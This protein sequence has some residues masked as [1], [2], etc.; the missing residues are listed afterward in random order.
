VGAAMTAVPYYTG[1]N[2]MWR[3][4]TQFF[5]PLPF[6]NPQ[7]VHWNQSLTLDPANV[8]ELIT[9]PNNPTGYFPNFHYSNAAV[10]IV[11]AVY[12]WPFINGGDNRKIMDADVVL[13]SLTKSSG[14]ASTR[15]A[16]AI[17]KNST[18]ANN[19]NTYI[20]AA[21]LASSSAIMLRTAQILKAM[22]DDNDFFDTTRHVMNERWE[23][24][25]ALLNPTRCPRYVL[26]S[27]PNTAYIWMRCSNSQE[28][29]ARN[30]QDIGIRGWVGS[31]FGTTSDYYRINLTL[32]SH[33]FNYLM[34][35]LAS[36]CGADPKTWLMHDTKNPFQ[37]MPAER[38]V[39][40][41]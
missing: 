28:Q 27:A 33:V 24:I 3:N 35:R 7:I 9:A 34:A 25:L 13:F 4:R 6:I 30:I 21:N 5:A 12:H 20:G 26:E 18:L 16:W 37:A 40:M 17:V 8:V 38:V 14:H 23:R 15:G 36:L 19:M 1:H 31:M 29:C 22:T 39:H 11:D 10:K 41:L 2:A 32:H